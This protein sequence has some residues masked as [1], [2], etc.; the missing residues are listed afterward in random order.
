MR[1]L[2]IKVIQDVV[3]R[4][5][6]DDEEALIRRCLCFT[7]IQKYASDRDRQD[8]YNNIVHFFVSQIDATQTIIFC[9]ERK[10]VHA[11][12]AYLDKEGIP[13]S[14]LRI[15]RWT[16]RQEEEFEGVSRS[17]DTNSRYDQC[18]FKGRRYSECGNRGELGYSS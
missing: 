15:N 8:C 16:R 3:T 17:K 5:I 6:I 1:V 11:L 13:A 7:L 18:D 9:E 4:S 14:F 12:K 10:I 2:K